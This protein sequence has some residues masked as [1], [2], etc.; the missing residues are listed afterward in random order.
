MYAPHWAPEFKRVKTLCHRFTTP[1]RKGGSCT[2]PTAVD[3]QLNR[4]AS[5]EIYNSFIF[6]SC[7]NQKVRNKMKQMEQGVRKDSTIEYK[8]HLAN[9]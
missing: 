8:I 6:S 4:L 5:Y 3:K 9:S 7:I 2:G 1:F